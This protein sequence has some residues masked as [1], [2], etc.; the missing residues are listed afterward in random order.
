M[1]L[2]VTL[3]HDDIE[4]A[5]REYAARHGHLVVAE[6]APVSLVAT[7]HDRMPGVSDFTASVEGTL[8]PAAVD[9]GP[10]KP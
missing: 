3:N 1:K 5:V 10:V 2:R 8:D 9:T 6:N 4:R 7:P